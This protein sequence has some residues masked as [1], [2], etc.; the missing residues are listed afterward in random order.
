ML[1]IG[2]IVLVIVVIFIVAVY[3]AAGRLFNGMDKATDNPA[4]RASGEGLVKNAEV[5]V[6]VG[7]HP[8]DLEYYTGGTEA[9]LTAAGKTVIGV[10]S[11]DKSD[12][13]EIRRAE[14][15]KAA[16]I[17][18]YKPVFLGHPEREY[19]GGLTDTDKREIR[20]EIREIIEENGADTVIAYD[21]ADQAPIYH[22]IDHIAT[23]KE[24]QA[25]AAEAG[26]E[27][28]YLYSS[29]HPDTRVDI[30]S[31]TA[32]KSAAMAAH[33]SQ[34]DRRWIKTLRIL[35]GWLRPG[36]SDS[37]ERYFTNSESFRK[38]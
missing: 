25:A 31:V 34:R 15:R 26:V 29:G 2:L 32:K 5:V 8:D 22:H 16:A 1:K 35:L 27:N 9:V 21:Y 23:G 17:L 11:A 30:G 4:A 20:Q 6:V 19:E 28:V 18:G 37:Q 3:L 12:E 7:A 14:A 24:A 33:E 36:G 10:L 13:Q 38:L